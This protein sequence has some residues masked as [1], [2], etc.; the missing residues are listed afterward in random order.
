MEKIESRP[1]EI[2]D[3]AYVYY[4]HTVEDP[5]EEMKIARKLTKKDCFEDG[6]KI[7]IISKPSLEK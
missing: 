3:W 4:S 7:Y 1:Q 2:A 5:T 6:D